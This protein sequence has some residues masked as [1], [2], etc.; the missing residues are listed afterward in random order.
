MK[1]Y[2]NPDELSRA[3]EIEKKD[4]KIIGFVPTMGA[5]HEGHL[6]LVRK[7]LEYDDITVVSIFV[8]PIQFNNKED[9]KKYP[10]I[11]DHDIQLLE[12]EG[13]H[14]IFTPTEKEMYPEGLEN[15]KEHYDFGHLDKILEGKYRPG[16]F[17]GV[18]VVVKR[19]FD[20]VRPHHAYFGKKDYQQLLIIKELVR[21]F[22]LPIEIIPAE[23]VR[24]PNGLAMSS[25]NLLLTEEQKELAS[26]IY[27]ALVYGKNLNTSV[28][29]TKEKVIKF[30]HNR[31][32]NDIEYFAIANKTNLTE[33]E[34]NETT[35]GKIALIAVNCCGVRLIDN[36]EY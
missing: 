8:N 26:N 15:I 34:E 3:L 13:V 5:L 29:E 33:A 9:L 36:M 24:E 16:H 7:S 4:G 14:Y 21:K 6:S 18:A 31:G 23:I 28:K 27:K 25:R 2:Q 32:I 17:N 10:R 20:I 1:I 35:H 30:L 11:L 22:D 19:L 12:K